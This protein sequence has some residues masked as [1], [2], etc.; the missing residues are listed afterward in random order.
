MAP[1]YTLRP[2]PPHLVEAYRRF[3]LVT[4][5]TTGVLLQRAADRLPDHEALVD[6][7]GAAPRRFTYAA[8]LDEV[9]RLATWLRGRGVGP[10]D[11]VLLQAPNAAEVVLGA[12]AAWR[13]GATVNPVVDIYRSH[14]LRHIV[15]QAR[16]DAVVTV[17]EHRG[18]RHAEGFDEVLAE[19]GVAPKA[20]LVLDDG[21]DGPVPGWTTWAEAVD[22][23][24]ADGRLELVD[25]DEPALVLFTSGTTSLPK[26]AVHSHRTLVAESLQMA[27]GWSM[28]WMDRMHLPLPIAHITGV[29]FALTVPVYRAGTV[30]LSRMV[31]LRQAV[32]EI[33]EHD[34]TTTA[35][36]P[37]AIPLLQEAYEKAGKATIPLRVLASGGTSV[38]K[39][40][41]EAAESLGVRPCRIYGMTEMP[42]LSMPCPAD[43][44]RQRLET[45]GIVAPGCECEAVDP[46]T[47]D[48]LPTGSEGELRV[49]GPE[50]MLGYLQPDQTDAQ[51]D[52]EG[53]FY[54]GD[55]GVVDD[56]GA[57]TVTGRI[58]DII[59]R[60]GEKFSAR[61]IEDVLIGHPRVAEVAV[62]AAPDRRY[63]EVPA[64]FVVAAG[65]DEVTEGELVAS[66]AEANVARQKT[67]VHWRFVDALPV[68][69]NGKVKKFELAAQVRG[70]VE[71]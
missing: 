41:I 59:N 28:G 10:G 1:N 3:G 57:V 67:P 23:D 4:D 44:E 51:I 22:N 71:P 58:K 27:N 39:V 42:T 52:G 47:R 9:E 35:S 14:E 21:P 65:D 26:G 69:P 37:H 45:D 5:E 36:A 61:D 60:G 7:S 32:D 24:G 8:A 17:A 31:S 50:R 63:G 62:V 33:V 15:D 46:A 64:A 53:W 2:Q 48:P 66:L 13:I 16:P 40:L 34:I 68:N 18:F 30:V 25:P 11:L 12:W 38:P 54:T 56:E 49:R 55:L 19:A 20:R 6:L 29:L 43:T 70:E